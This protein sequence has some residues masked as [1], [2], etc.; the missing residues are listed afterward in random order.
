MEDWAIVV[1]L[2]QYR[3]IK[4]KTRTRLLTMDGLNLFL[5][6]TGAPLMNI[7]SCII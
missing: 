4:A 3:S 6:F 5:I 7:T 2:A 1:E